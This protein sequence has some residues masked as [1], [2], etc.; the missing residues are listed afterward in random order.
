M[1]GELATTAQARAAEY[2]VRKSRYNQKSFRKDEAEHA[3][4][5][6]WELVRE[7]QNTDRYQKIKP[8]DEQ[9]E[10]EFWCL[11]Y[12]F[13]YPNLNV[14]RNFQIEVTKDARTTVS[15]QI[16]VFAFD[17][18]TIVIAECKFAEKRT[19]KSLLK[20]I[21][22]FAG[23]QRAISNTLRKLFKG[24]FD[25]K[26]IWLFV[27][28]NIDWSAADR[29][30]AAEYNIKIVAESEFPYYKEIAKRI[31]RSARY[32][33]H[34]EFLARAKVSALEHKLF[35]LRTKLGPHR[36]YT[37]FADART[38][39][40]ITFVN[41]RDL[42]D[43]NAAPSYQRLI[44]KQR[45]KDIANFIR[46]GGFFPNSIILNFKRKVRFDILKPEDENGIAVGQITL[47]NTYKSAWII[48]GQ[49]RL[50]SYTEMDENDPSPHLPFL[51]FENIAIFEETKIFADINSK[52]KSVSR[53]LLD[54]ITGEIKIESSDKREQT[55]AI[56]SRAFDLMRDN[57][58]GPLGDKIA[59]SEIKRSEGSIITIPY[60]VDATAQVGLLG[61]VVQASGSVTFIQG[62]LHWEEPKE[63]ITA[64]CELLEGYFDLFR[65]ANFQRWDSG[66][67]GMFATNVGIAGLIRFLADLIAYMSAKEHQDPR[68]LHPTVIVERVEKYAEPIC[69]YFK[70]ATDEEIQRRLYTPF[71]SGGPRVF[72]HR[73]REILRHSFKDFDPPGFQEDLRKYDEIRKHD[74]DQKVRVIQDTV[75]RCVLNKLKEVYCSSD[76]DQ[77]LTK[78]VDNKKILEEA[79][80]RQL[81][82]DEADRKDL[83]TYLDFIDL[84]KI[85]EMPRHWE[86]FKAQLNIQ[87]PGEHG[88]A[89][90]LGWFDEINKLRRVS[91]HPYN[92]GYDDAQVEKLNLIYAKLKERNVL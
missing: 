19:K 62:P 13:G 90:Y 1:L 25:Q 16:D 2:R 63:A 46:E 12:S 83:G 3:I 7:N 65:F 86:H 66:K 89:K 45:V 20:D 33:F 28:R 40:P 84:R 38:I 29:A 39:L 55:K 26:I 51:A 50:Y 30:R 78:A 58:D 8:H 82:A 71:G 32:Q 42:R 81:D 76:G 77:Y 91:A 54:E 21:G 79:F 5:E 59:G 73:L 35:A 68:E 56:S 75:Q 27:T 64:L 34:A 9:L 15:K 14:G 53:K 47:P 22:E 87:M 43:P 67:S 52:Q 48:D 49:H 85:V 60:L 44:H 72:Q 61:K 6:G 11:A 36:A 80:S 18:E 57:D 37:F 24:S 69:R 10:N 92:R 31:G 23:N 17:S 41:H 70:D 74:A 88:R 4:S